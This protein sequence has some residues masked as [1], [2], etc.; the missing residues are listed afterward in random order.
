MKKTIL[1]ML[2]IILL[3]FV[4]ACNKPEFNGNRTGDDSRFIMDYTMM[5][6]TETHELKL[7]Q[8]DSVNVS[9]ESQSGRLDILFT[10]SSGN[11]IYKGDNAASGSYVL[12]II[13]SDIYIITV[14]GKNAK[15][16]V[17]FIANKAKK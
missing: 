13:K 2:C 15:G 9:I 8:G 1:P 3:F 17:S 11:E 10:D 4:T 7:E 16:S 6:K 5:N 12:E 14:T